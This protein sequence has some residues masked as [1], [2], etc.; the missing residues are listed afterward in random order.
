MSEPDTPAPE[1]TLDTLLDGQV[2]LHQFA[3]GYRAGMDAVLLAA[4]LEARPGEHVVE[5]GC[6][7]GAVLLCAAKRLEGVSFT[8]HEKDPNAVSLAVDNIALNGLAD[9]VEIQAGDIAQLRQN[10]SADQVVFNPPFFDDPKA[11]RTPKP[12]KQAAWL[13]GSAPLGVW[14]QA[15][16]RALKAKGRLTLIHRADKLAD[17]LAA[18]DK[19]FGSVV[20]KPIQS[21]SGQPAKRILV[22]ARIGGRAPLQLLAPLVL[23]EGE[24]FTPE[25]DALMR[26]R[27]VLAMGG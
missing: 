20:I 3:D 19:S 14:V 18:L 5:F 27:A 25:A 23:H 26:G 17:I 24:G 1:T 6:G 10:H 11:L 8:G 16:A 9:R 21:R 13:S 15:A 22:T 2:R 7:A 12:G 4:A